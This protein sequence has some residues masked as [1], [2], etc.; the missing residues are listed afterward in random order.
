MN[1]RRG[2]ENGEAKFSVFY[3]LLAITHRVPFRPRPSSHGFTTDLISVRYQQETGSRFL[4]YFNGEF[5]IHE[6]F[7]V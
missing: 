2:A 4:H 7:F 3:E 1:V 6:T 5:D